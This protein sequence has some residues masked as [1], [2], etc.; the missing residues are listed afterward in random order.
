[1]Y[2][3]YLLSRGSMSA[4]Y[5]RPCASS[6]SRLDNR[7]SRLSTPECTV[8]IVGAGSLLVVA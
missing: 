6:C 5:A 4:A 8:P 1:M 2:V 3:S 7:T